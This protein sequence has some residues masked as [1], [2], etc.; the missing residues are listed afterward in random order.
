MLDRVLQR[1]KAIRQA[2]PV[3]EVS[4][5]ATAA[6]EG[7]RK[8][9][10]QAGNHSSSMRCAKRTRPAWRTS[11][12][13]EGRPWEGAPSRRMEPL[14]GTEQSLRSRRVASKSLALPDLRAQQPRA[15]HN[16]RKLVGIVVRTCRPG[17]EPRHRRQA[18]I[19][20][21]RTPHCP[22]KRARAPAGA[23]VPVAQDD[24][25]KSSCDAPCR[26][27]QGLPLGRIASDYCNR[28]SSRNQMASCA[29][30]LFFSVAAVLTTIAI[31][32][33]NREVT[34]R[35]TMRRES[36]TGIPFPGPGQ[37]ILRNFR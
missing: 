14:R 3:G 24:G 27:E 2:G 9:C 13:S 20:S 34:D 18:T 31:L 37:P 11:L 6:I 35:T 4:E 21:R 23:S 1:V 22:E 16:S 7:G 33:D 5:S 28:R 17:H 25:V 15:G 10:A 19:P 36:G 32:P 30:R 29:S 26:R 8:T 12:A